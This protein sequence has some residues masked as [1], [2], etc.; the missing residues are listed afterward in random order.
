M[1]QRTMT[2]DEEC[3]YYNEQRERINKWK[4]L[5]QDRLEQRTLTDYVRLYDEQNGTT[6]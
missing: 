1:E 4:E 3:R 5:N 2:L 6:S